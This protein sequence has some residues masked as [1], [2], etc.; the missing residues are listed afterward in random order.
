MT[1]IEQIK[2]FFRLFTHFYF[3]DDDKKEYRYIYDI[4]HKKILVY[5]LPTGPTQLATN[6][7]SDLSILAILILGASPGIPMLFGETGS[8]SLKYRNIIF[9]L[10]LAVSI[11]LIPIFQ[12]WFQSGFQRDGIIQDVAIDKVS[13]LYGISTFR[14]Q[15]RMELKGKTEK[16]L[17]KNF[18]IEFGLKAELPVLIFILA[19]VNMIYYLPAIG[20]V[21]IISICFIMIC[22][23]GGWTIFYNHLKIKLIAKILF[24][25]NNEII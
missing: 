21:T 23:L 4:K 25:N 1:K 11:I 24:S 7:V 8:P 12:A 6:I 17:M 2:D 16:E 3:V 22:S 20:S 19:C 15:Y 10:S 5:K 18:R 9:I 14:E 13:V